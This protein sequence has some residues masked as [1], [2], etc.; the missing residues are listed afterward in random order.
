MIKG[1]ANFKYDI[2]ICGVAFKKQNT[3]DYVSVENYGI[4]YVI[5]KDGY[6]IVD[7]KH[8]EKLVDNTS[9]ETKTK[10]KK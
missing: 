7:K 4:V 9:K 2:I 8:I 3:Y 1:K 10:G 6:V 5:T